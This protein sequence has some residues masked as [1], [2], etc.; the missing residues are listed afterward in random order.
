[1]KDALRGEIKLGTYYGYSQHSSGITNIK[2]GKAVKLNDKTVTLKVVIHNTALY[3]NDPEPKIVYDSDK[4]SVK[5]NTLFPVSASKV[6]SLKDE[7]GLLPRVIKNMHHYEFE[8]YCRKTHAQHQ[9]NI[10]DGEDFIPFVEWMADMAAA[11][12]VPN[13]SD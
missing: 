12:G 13:F 8:Q 7:K 5:A 2:I 1:M 10:R 4:V 9:A 11:Y 6:N 3:E